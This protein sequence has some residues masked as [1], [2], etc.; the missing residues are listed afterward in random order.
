MPQAG[1]PSASMMDGIE[2]DAIGGR[3]SHRRHRRH[4]YSA[5]YY[6]YGYDNDEYDDYYPETTRRSRRQ[7]QS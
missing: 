4:D 3:R 7:T 1:F 2:E 6:D 5:D